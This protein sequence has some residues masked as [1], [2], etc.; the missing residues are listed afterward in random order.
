MLKAISSS[1]CVLRPMQQNAETRL[2]HCQHWQGGLDEHDLT[3]M[4]G[5]VA[6]KKCEVNK[7]SQ[8]W[9]VLSTRSVQ[10]SIRAAR[11][12]VCIAP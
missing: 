10:N 2:G 1:W 3:G 4:T 12:L 5:P 11:L 6:S 7:L 8:G 9:L